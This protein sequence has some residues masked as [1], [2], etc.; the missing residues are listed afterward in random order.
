MARGIFLGLVLLLALGCNTGLETNHAYT[1]VY[2]VA[3]KDNNFYY[4]WAD[5]DL[6]LQNLSKEAQEV[7]NLSYVQDLFLLPDKQTFLYSDG[8]KLLQFSTVNKKTTLD[9]NTTHLYAVSP[10]GRFALIARSD[11]SLY[12]V[13]DLTT[14]P[15]STVTVWGATASGSIFLSD[16]VIV[17]REHQTL[18]DT[19]GEGHMVL[20]YLQSSANDT[21]A[22]SEGGP[23]VLYNSKS[24]HLYS[25]NSLFNTQTL[26]QEDIPAW[27]DHSTILAISSDEALR[28]EQTNVNGQTSYAMHNIL[29]GEQQQL[30]LRAP[31]APL[32]SPDGR[33]LILSNAPG[34]G[35]HR[36][37]LY[38]TPD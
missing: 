7:Y 3:W 6:T 35:S 32:F 19:S 21:I 4:A 30:D 13:I 18:A 28:F 10:S 15:I 24:N 36:L 37:M 33:H 9:P 38:I 23:I 31:S 25:T 12:E 14:Q 20:H 29:T 11:A 26:V 16:G 1:D 17:Q 2:P 27:N 5:G 22:F 8:T 34:N